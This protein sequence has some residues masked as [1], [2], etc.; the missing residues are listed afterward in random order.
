MTL[1]CPMLRLGMLSENHAIDMKS[2]HVST[3]QIRCNP[4]QS[5]QSLSLDKLIFFRFPES[6]PWCSQDLSSDEQP[7]SVWQRSRT[8]GPA[9][10]LDKASMTV[11]RWGWKI[12]GSV[13]Q[14]DEKSL[15]PRSS[16]WPVF[17]LNCLRNRDAK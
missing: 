4:M 15:P 5:H 13:W 7:L 16:C 8:F 3:N 17:I 12:V 2:R 9:P 11:K 10:W 14:L 1:L 6:S